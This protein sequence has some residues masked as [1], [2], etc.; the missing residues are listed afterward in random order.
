VAKK[1]LMSPVTLN[2]IL[3]TAPVLI[4]G[5]TRL[6]K[7]IRDRRDPG[8]VE[9]PDTVEGIKLE[10]ERLH[11]RLDDDTEANVEQARLVETLAKQQEVLAKK[12][13]STMT[14]LNR[15]IIGLVT[16]AVVAVIAL[17]LTLVA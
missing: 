7:L 11:H 1:L 6:I 3:N 15:V 5:A 14:H 4:Q 16:V 2:T 9:I 8:A 12:L 17:Y 10:V 13:R